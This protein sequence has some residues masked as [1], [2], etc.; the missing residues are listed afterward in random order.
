MKKH[1]AIIL[2]ILLM[3][4]NISVLASGDELEFTPYI[5]GYQDGT[6]RPDEYVSVAEAVSMVSNLSADFKTVGESAEF[7]DVSADSWYSSAVSDL[8]SKGFLTN[9]NN[10]LNPDSAISR[11]QMA[12][13]AYQLKNGATDMSF[14][15]MFT[16]A[17]TEGIIVGDDGGYRS[18]ESLT[19]AEAVT[20]INRVL[21]ENSASRAAAYCI[22]AL[23]RM[24]LRRIGHLTIFF[25]L[26]LRHI[27]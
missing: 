5:N 9:F 26:L 23:F 25:S 8:S 10:K 20:M 6:F 11:L 15:D 13:L 17:I 21:N 16:K 2:T 4:A 22:R 27:L 24:L 12:S 18:E 7:T 19:R 3:L 14:F 1:I